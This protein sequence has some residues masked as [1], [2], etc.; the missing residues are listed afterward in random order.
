MPLLDLVCIELILVEVWRRGWDIV[1]I[2]GWTT[3]VQGVET[4]L[5]TIRTIVPVAG[6]ESSEV[7]PVVE[8][9]KLN[10]FITEPVI[11]P[12]KLPVHG[13]LVGPAVEP[14]SNRWHHKYKIYILLKLKI[15]INFFKY[16]WI[17]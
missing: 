7:E 1:A 10:V 16:I 15:I 6:Q 11:E 5:S 17:N 12:E 2:I 4:M 13:S 14:L 8:L 9:E 3:C